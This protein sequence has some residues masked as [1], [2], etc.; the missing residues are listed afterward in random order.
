MLRDELTGLPGAELLGDRLAQALAR[1][2]RGMAMAVLAIE[3]DG[4]SELRSDLGDAAAEELLAAMAARLSGTLRS[5]DTLAH[6]GDGSFVALCDGVG[7]ED[8]VT[9][10]ADRLL[11]GAASHFTLAGQER[12]VTISIGVTVPSGHESDEQVLAEAR[13]LTGLARTAGGGRYELD[14]S[15][16]HRLSGS[17]ALESELRDAIERDRLRL[18]YQPAYSLDDGTI[19]SVEALLRWDHERR[20]IIAPGEFL[21]AVAQSEVIVDLGRWTLEEA[22]RQL[23]IWRPSLA[24]AELYLTVNL[25]AEQLLSGQ[26]ASYLETAAQRSDAPLANLAL[27]VAAEDLENAP[28]QA[29]DS[30]RELAGLGPGL[31]VDQL[32]SGRLP[33][34]RLAG[35][36]LRALK[37]SP[38]LIAGLPD[39]ARST[40]LAR[41]GIEAGRELGV[42]TIAQG[43]ETPGQLEALREFG[44]ESVSGFL[45]S[46]PMPASVLEDTLRGSVR[47]LEVEE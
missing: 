15:L 11:R 16:S 17:H 35:L 10:I 37:I 23:S 21:D 28:Q 7:R 39:D 6:A 12:F 43:V 47:L 33:L 46:V 44:C 4:L 14:P 22:C 13:R 40:A 8:H 1:A 9:L 41:K 29:I 34:E 19:G 27:E 45:M 2:R 38:K 25:S 20:G 26:I 31:V 32:A 3:V 42:E 36:P 24:A 30:L 5:M 18:F